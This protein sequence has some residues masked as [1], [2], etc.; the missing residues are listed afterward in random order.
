VREK[1]EKERRGAEERTERKMC[2]TGPD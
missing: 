1:E 2:S